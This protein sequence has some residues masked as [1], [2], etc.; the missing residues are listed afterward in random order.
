MTGDP[1][2]WPSRSFT[3]GPFVLIPERQLLLQRG[4]P[5]RIGNRAMDMLTLLV[6]RPGDVVSKRDLL[7]HVWPDTIVEEGNLKVNMTALRRALGDGAGAARYIATV[8]GRGYRFIAPVQ[9]FEA[10]GP[11]LAL[12]AAVTDGHH[13]PAETTRIFGRA[14]TIDT[15]RRDLNES[16]LVSIVGA[17]GI[18]KTTVAIA[19]ARAAA[20]ERADGAAFIDLATI[21]DSQF[22]P[23]AIASALGL[24]MT[25]GDP[26]A[27][28]VHVLKSQQKVLLLDNCEHLLAAVAAAVDRLTRDLADVRIIATSREPLRLRGE[29]VH[30]LRGLECDP[31]ESPKADEARTFPAVELFATRASERAGYRLTDADA[32][33]VAEIC[34]RLDGNALAIELAATQTAAFSPARILQM[35]DDSFRLLNLGPRGAPPRQQS[36]LATLDWSYSLLSE[37]EAA[38]LRAISVFA[39]IFSADG[40]TA[41]SNRR[42]AEVVDAL[43]QLAAKSLL[44]MDNNAEIVSYRLLETTRAYCIERLRISGEDKAVRRRHAEHVCAVLEQAESEWSQRPAREWS[45][46]YGHV[47]DDLRA[48]LAWAGPDEANRPLRIRLTVAGLLLWNHFSLIEEC[49]AHVSR[50]VE[51]LDAAGL[52]GT[53]LEMKFKLWLGGSTM[54]TRGLKPQAMDALRRAWWIADQ[55]GDTD[56]RH[57][58]L[59]LIAAYE[60]FTGEYDAGM[61]TIETFASVAAADDPSI[62]PEGEVHLGIA[63]LFLGRLQ[64]ARRRFEALQRRDLRYF[65]GSYSVRYMADIVVLLECALSQVQWLTGFP[66]TAARTATAAFER[67]RPAHHH[68]SL[69]N[70]LTYACPIFYWSGRYEECGRYVELLTEHVTRQ[71]LITRRPIASFYRAALA[72]TQS[73]ASS[74]GIDDLKQAIEEFRNVNYLARMPYYLSVLADALAHGGQLG[75][76]ET[77]LRTALDIAH[78]QNESWC[79]PELLRVQASILTAQGRPDDAEAILVEAMALAREIGALSWRLRAANDLATLW[80]VRSRADDARRLLLPVYTEFT[81][82]FATRDL[83]V[84]ASLLASLSRPEGHVAV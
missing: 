4:T 2:E 45:A 14:D 64:D 77:T 30:R 57:R 53:A 68:L 61:R 41:V 25:A 49:H 55:I 84:T 63:E 39:G 7:S 8:T 47:V 58:C 21:G 37:P 13:L 71:G 67:A 27:S 66:D 81:E 29:R 28:V 1:A 5:V 52:G 23:T 10:S 65:N 33:A 40:A 60:L 80:Q 16:R 79:L 36:L 20:R 74:V 70:A 19:A 31:H 35:L 32:P 24:G 54:I 12:T 62:L 69:N 15:V 43:A 56:Y 34:R 51:E 18:G 22:V 9:K 76:A 26:L 50:A 46:A 3:F 72:Y 44:A 73:G 78:A 11:S 42:P 48:A 82:G 83:M 17:G 38:L 6:E 75:E 59:M